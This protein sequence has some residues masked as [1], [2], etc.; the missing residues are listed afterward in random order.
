MSCKLTV[1]EI[2]QAK[3]DLG[4]LSRPVS[5]AYMMIQEHKGNRMKYTAAYERLHALI[6]RL[7]DSEVT[8]KG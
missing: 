5:D 6:H 1:R 2:A 8:V 3:E 4:M 7:L